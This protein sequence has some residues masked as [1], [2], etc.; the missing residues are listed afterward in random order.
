MKK[1]GFVLW[2]CL[3]A[4][5]FLHAR[6]E[7]SVHVSVTVVGTVFSL[8]LQDSN[9]APWSGGIDFGKVKP[10]ESVFPPSAVVV[11]ACKSNT[12][13]PW[14]LQVNA[15]PLRDS[16]SGISVP[17]ELFKVYV[18]DPAEQGQ[19]GLP[20]KRYATGESPRPLKQNAVTVYA[21]NNKGDAGFGGGWGTYVPVGFGITVPDTQPQGQ[22]ESMMTFTMTE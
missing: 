7:D 15:T 6:V 5:S 9:G 4:M 12:G 18:G 14:S 20:G 21:S 11:A 10:G 1:C 8:G 17:E 13:Q 16:Q 19:L 22:Y 3:L 2:C